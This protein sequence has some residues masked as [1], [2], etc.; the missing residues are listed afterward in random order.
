MLI[1]NFD[2][3]TFNLLHS[4]EKSENV[5][6]TV[7]RNNCLLD[8][9]MSR[10]H[11]IV[12]SPGPGLPAEAGQLHSFIEKFHQEKSI[13]G[14]CLGHQALGQFFNAKLKNLPTV[15]HGIQLETRLLE[16][17]GM[18]NLLPETIQTGHYHSWV[19]DEINFP[20]CLKITAHN[21]EGGIMAFKHISLDIAGIQFHP[22]S[23]LTPM[24]D[25]IIHNWLNN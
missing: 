20:A 5:H 13:L 23:V 12:I 7:V 14:I 3:F 15:L 2:S 24:G 11:K 21:A 18:F 25:S 1:D 17:K 4:L 19:L 16:Q 6:V 10:F 22:E 8:L 9:E